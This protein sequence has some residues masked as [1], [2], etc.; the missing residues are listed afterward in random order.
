VAYPHRA[1]NPVHLAAPAI[2]E[3]AAARWDE[4]NEYFPPTTFQVSNIHAGS[5]AQ[6]IIPGVLQVDF[7]F[8]FSTESTPESLKARVG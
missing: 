6:N 5:G 3:L 8:R 7:N 2:A 1:K 4:G